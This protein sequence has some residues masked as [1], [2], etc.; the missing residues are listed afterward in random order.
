M[1]S[2]YKSFV[3]LKFSEAKSKVFLQFTQEQ[4]PCPI[5]TTSVTAKASTPPTTAPIGIMYM[6]I[7][8]V[9]CQPF[10][11]LMWSRI[12]FNVAINLT[13]SIGLLSITHYS[14]ISYAALVLGM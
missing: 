7:Y 12:S 1:H 10:I 6:I 5:P 11:Y 3:S 4:M 14:I 9:M 13:W 8:V 2:I